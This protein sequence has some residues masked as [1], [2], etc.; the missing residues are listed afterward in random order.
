MEQENGWPF[1]LV[2]LEWA[3]TARGEKIPLGNGLP[4]PF[5]EL[6]KKDFKLEENS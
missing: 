1:K 4:A 6:L 3:E 5:V 2:Y